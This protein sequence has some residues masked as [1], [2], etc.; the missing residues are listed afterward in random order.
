MLDRTRDRWISLLMI[1]AGVAA[2]AWVDHLAKAGEKIDMEL[3]GIVAI[4][5]TFGIAGL[6]EPALLQPYSSKAPR[7]ARVGMLV[8]LVATFGVGYVVVKAYG[9]R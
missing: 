4:G 6:F 5:I 7:R 9:I 8:A 1:V 2:L 3:A